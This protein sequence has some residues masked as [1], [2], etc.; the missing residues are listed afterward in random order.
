VQAT[1]SVGSSIGPGTKAWE[2]KRQTVSVNT[3]ACHVVADSATVPKSANGLVHS[4][5]LIKAQIDENT[6]EIESALLRRQV[7][8]DLS[9]DLTKQLQKMPASVRQL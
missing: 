2:E 1:S 7:L 8:L 9:D 4:L 5:A 6:T 3:K